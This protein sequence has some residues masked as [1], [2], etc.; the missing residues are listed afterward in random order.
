LAT[1]LKKFA[2]SELVMNIE[3][4]A[5]PDLNRSVRPRLRNVEPFDEQPGCGQADAG[6]GNSHPSPTQTLPAALS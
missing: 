5:D 3:A 2:D 6:N 4:E 1:G